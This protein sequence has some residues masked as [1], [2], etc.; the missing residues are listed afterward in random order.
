MEELK[1]KIEQIFAHVQQAKAELEQ[2]NV[3]KAHEEL[4]AA[5]SIPVTIDDEGLDF[6]DTVT[7][8][9]TK[10]GAE[11]VNKHQRDLQN[12]HPHGEYKTDYKE[13]DEYSGQFWVIVSLLPVFCLGQDVYIKNIKK[14]SP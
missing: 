14:R 13:G 1:N 12:I 6:N 11:L 4:I 9:L 5:L 2:M 8:I 10:D 7:C 3:G